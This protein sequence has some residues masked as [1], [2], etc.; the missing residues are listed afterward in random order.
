MARMEPISPQ[1]GS[2][3]TDAP[4]TA[5]ACDGTIVVVRHDKTK[6]EQVHDMMDALRTVDAQVLGTI[7]SRS[8]AT[9]KRYHYREYGSESAGGQ[10]VPDGPADQSVGSRGR[11]GV[12]R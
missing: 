2:A 11:S 12:G 5:A 10:P 4:A 3:F 8:P 6:R 9:G 7:P 1:H